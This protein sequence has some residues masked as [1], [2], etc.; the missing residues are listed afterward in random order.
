MWAVVVLFGDLKWRQLFKI[1]SWSEVFPPPAPCVPTNVTAMKNCGQSFAKVTWRASHGAL[2]YQ[3][4]AV[5]QDGEHLQ[6]SSNVTSCM[7]EGLMCSRV[8]RVVVTAMDDTCTSNESS[9]ETLQTGRDKREAI[10]E[11]CAFSRSPTH[12]IL[13]FCVFPLQRPALPLS[14]TPL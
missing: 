9:V 2:R 1:L 6:C 11:I 4:T 3:V 14:S 8:Y 10:P 13:M 12:T 5:D 7:L